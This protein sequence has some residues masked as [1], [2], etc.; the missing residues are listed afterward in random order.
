MG[1]N[2]ILLSGCCLGAAVVISVVSGIGGATKGLQ[3]NANDS[4]VKMAAT[5]SASD[6]K[7][8][9]LDHAKQLTNLIKDPSTVIVVTK[10]IS[11]ASTK[12][13]LQTMRSVFKPG[14]RITIG[15]DIGKTVSAGT[16][17]TDNI[18]AIGIVNGQGQ[19]ENPFNPL[20]THL[21][22]M[23]PD[24]IRS[25]RNFQQ[26]DLYATPPEALEVPSPETL[27]NPN[28]AGQ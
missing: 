21:P 6:L 2:A 19:I 1:M 16:Y 5:Q 24:Q 8:E 23:T 28:P 17:V 9:K 14:A 12:D 4:A 25:F 10:Q 15:G 18:G 20:A 27:V 3:R 13:R 7:A 26:N 22:M 11:A